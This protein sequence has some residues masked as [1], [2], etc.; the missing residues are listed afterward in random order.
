MLNYKSIRKF[1][2][3]LFLIFFLGVVGFY[4]GSKAYYTNRKSDMISVVKYAMKYS[5]QH[6]LRK[7]KGRKYTTFAYYSP[8]K[9][10]QKNPPDSITV[11]FGNK[12]KCTYRLERI[13]NDNE[14]SSYENS[15]MIRSFLLYVNPINPDSLYDTWKSVYS[16]KYKLKDSGLSIAVTSSDSEETIIQYFTNQHKWCSSAQPVANYTIGYLNE[17]E[18]TGYI[19]YTFWQVFGLFGLCYSL[20][21]W[22]IIF[23]VV[24]ICNQLHKKYMLMSII[25]N[26]IPPT[27]IHEYKLHEGTSFYP[28]LHKLSIDG[29]EHILTSQLAILLTLFLES[30]DHKLSNSQI[31]QALWPDGSATSDRIQKVISRLRKESRGDTLFRISQSINYY[32]L[33]L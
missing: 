6:E 30:E 2:Y 33:M 31:S 8:S 21:Y 14:T 1:N 9:R 10:L 22:I 16:K 19:S 12:R 23:G 13:W 20:L 29:E 11:S 27:D 28:E 24:V 15:P 3:L 26:K 5:I 4:F 7:L 18:I 32:Q 17:V 25:N